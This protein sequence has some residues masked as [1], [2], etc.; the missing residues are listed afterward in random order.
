EPEAVFCA[1]YA[2]REHAIWLDSARVGPGVARFSFIGA[3]DGPLGQVVRYDVETGTL[4]VD[5]A[6]GREVSETSV[7]D[8][9]RDE[10]AR[11]R[12]DA[13]ELPFDFTCGFAGYLGYEL[14]AECGDRV[15]QTS[16]LPDAALLLCD[17]VVAFDHREGRIHLLAL[18][19]AE[20]RADADAWLAATGERLRALAR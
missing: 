10:L 4:V 6:S 1:L 16:T 19:D 20:G 15:T 12:A 5:R 3:P 9:C 8:H 18:T 17:R 11:L 13:P 7:L 2:E 14:K